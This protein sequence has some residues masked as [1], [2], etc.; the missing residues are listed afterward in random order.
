MVGSLLQSSSLREEMREFLQGFHGHL[1]VVVVLSLFIDFWYVYFDGY[2]VA[3]K[4][5]TLLSFVYIHSNEL[6]VIVILV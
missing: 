3:C 5:I 1:E 4:P 6:L 2:Y